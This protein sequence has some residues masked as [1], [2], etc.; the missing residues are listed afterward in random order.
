MRCWRN[1]LNESVLR[2][3]PLGG[4]LLASD[5]GVRCHSVCVVKPCE[6]ECG[7]FFNALISPSPTYAAVLN[8][9][10]RPFAVNGC[11]AKWLV[12]LG[13]PLSE[14]LKCV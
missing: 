6:D 7:W 10:E 1:E 3:L 14:L 2:V 11:D 13:S 9:V 8:R 5:V 12:P 4:E